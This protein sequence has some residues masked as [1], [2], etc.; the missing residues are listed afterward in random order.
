MW[1]GKKWLLNFYSL[2]LEKDNK[3]FHKETHF[4]LPATR[5]RSRS[6]VHAIDKHPRIATREGGLIRQVI[7][8]IKS[9]RLYFLVVVFAK[10]S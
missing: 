2:W 8:V 6:R 7:S 3:K 10:P 4:V 1:F 5:E 9:V